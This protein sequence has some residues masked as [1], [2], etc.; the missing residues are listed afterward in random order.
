MTVA[1]DMI[2]KKKIS[3]SRAAFERF[4]SLLLGCNK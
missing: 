4:L 1:G 2:K 3:K